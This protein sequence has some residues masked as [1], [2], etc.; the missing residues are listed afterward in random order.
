MWRSIDIV[1]VV[2][3]VLNPNE[4]ISLKK[5]RLKTPSQSKRKRYLIVNVKKRF[6]C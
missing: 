2:E 1:K 3:F 4:K 5:L 6:L